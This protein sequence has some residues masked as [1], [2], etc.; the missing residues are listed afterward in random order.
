MSVTRQ[1]G[2][3]LLII[4]A[5]DGERITICMP[6]TVKTDAAAIELAKELNR[7]S[8]NDAVVLRRVALIQDAGGMTRV[9][10]E[11]EEVDREDREGYKRVAPA[12]N[13]AQG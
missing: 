13:G 11:R 6:P 10:E 9:Q 4:R 7:D 12:D 3:V 1:D 5:T 2:Y 8:G